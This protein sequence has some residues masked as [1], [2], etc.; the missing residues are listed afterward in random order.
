[1][2]KPKTISDSIE[3]LIGGVMIH[4]GIRN[5]CLFMKSLGIYSNEFA[6]DANCA[7]A[8]WFKKY[9][10]F[11]HDPSGKLSEFQTTMYRRNDF[12]SLES[13]MGYTFK[14]KA[15]LIQA[16]KHVSHEHREFPSYERLEFLGKFILILEKLENS[17][18]S[19]FNV[20][21]SKSKLLN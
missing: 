14:N 1:M 6:L 12:K 7:Q 17:L 16:F 9:D 15:L 8:N 18:L 4:S 19:S 11:E 10:F 5:A 2:L 21:S 3:A 13:K 20:Q